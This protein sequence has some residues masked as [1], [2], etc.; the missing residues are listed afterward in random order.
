MCYKKVFRNFIKHCN[1]VNTTVVIVLVKIESNLKVYMYT[2]I[3][4]RLQ[5]QTKLTKIER[6]YYFVYAS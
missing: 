6:T 4:E 1:R 2:I 5:H 3:T